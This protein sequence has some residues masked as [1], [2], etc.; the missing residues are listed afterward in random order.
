MFIYSVA[1]SKWFSMVTG[2]C[3]AEYVL[4]LTLKLPEKLQLYGP[5]V[6]YVVYISDFGVLRVKQQSLKMWEITQTVEKYICIHHYYNVSNIKNT[7][8]LTS[9]LFFFNSHLLKPTVIF[10]I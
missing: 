10:I 3:I 2:S 7:S 4:V 8:K 5:Y 9:S 1:N 6:Y